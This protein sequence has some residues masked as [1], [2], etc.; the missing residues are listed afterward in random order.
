M[1]SPARFT[2]DLDLGQQQ[3]HTP[4]PG[5][6]EDLVGQLVRQAREEGF[7]EGEKA[8]EQSTTAMAAQTLA[9]A[10]AAL[11]ARSSEMAQALDAARDEHVAE[12]VQLAAAIG[13]KLAGHLIARYPLAEI[14]ALVAECMTSLQGAPHLVIRCHPDLADAVR[15]VATANM[16][17]SGFSGRLVVMGEP[18]R[19]LGD[20][21]LEWVD[22][23]V[24]RDLGTISASIDQTISAY[25]AARG[26]TD[27]E[28]TSP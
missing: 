21:R 12:A 13:R 22:G 14:E 5:V 1:A 20:A 4:S 18:E 23:G 10:A 9:S 26:I 28:E 2:F 11:S 8:G 27:Q 17:T 7:A 25:L 15:D 24:E 19:R 3:H 6:P 16:A